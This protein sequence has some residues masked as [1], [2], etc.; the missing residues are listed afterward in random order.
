METMVETPELE[1]LILQQSPALNNWLYS[2]SELWA[3]FSSIFALFLFVIWTVRFTFNLNT[4]VL[5]LDLYIL[6]ILVAIWKSNYR[7]SIQELNGKQR[8]T[9]IKS[10]IAWKRITDSVIGLAIISSVFIYMFSN[11]LPANPEF[12]SFIYTLTL[13]IH[14]L[15]I[16]VVPALSRINSLTILKSKIIILYTDGEIIS[17]K[18]EIHPLDLQISVDDLLAE[19][20]VSAS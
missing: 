15:I 5:L 8:I 12:V 16:P 7:T 14:V 17:I 11:A 9:F 3:G 1:E 19:R 6:G 4:W 10:G 2:K 13:I 18:P 20:K